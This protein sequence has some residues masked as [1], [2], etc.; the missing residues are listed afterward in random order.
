MSR[1]FPCHYVIYVII[2]SFRALS[3]KVD[4]SFFFSKKSLKT[5]AKSIVYRGIAENMM[6]FLFFSPKSCYMEVSLNLG[7]LR[8][9]KNGVN[10]GQINPQERSR[11]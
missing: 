2:V 11:S 7:H 6:L 9:G 5:F 3:K 10:L 8:F 1:M 4:H